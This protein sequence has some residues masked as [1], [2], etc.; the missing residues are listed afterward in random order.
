VN[1][2]LQVW[3]HLR[4]V[5]IECVFPLLNSRS[6]ILNCCGHVGQTTILIAI[7]FGRKA[8]VIQVAT[9]DVPDEMRSP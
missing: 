6:A 5:E 7:S 4:H 8:R 1:T 9:G 3:R 2:D